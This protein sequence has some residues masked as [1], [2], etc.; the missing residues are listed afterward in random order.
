MRKQ[1]SESNAVELAQLLYWLMIVGFML[2][3]MEV[4]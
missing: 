4:R 2:R 3:Q 1:Q